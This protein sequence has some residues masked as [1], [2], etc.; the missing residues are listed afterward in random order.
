MQLVNGSTCAPV[1]GSW[2]RCV[3]KKVQ[4]LYSKIIFN[5]Y[6]CIHHR[7]HTITPRYICLHCLSLFGTESFFL[8]FKIR[9][10][11]C[12]TH[13]AM[14]AGGKKTVPPDNWALVHLLKFHTRTAL[15]KFSLISYWFWE[16]NSYTAD[17][18][19][20]RPYSSASF[21]SSPRSNPFKSRAI[22]NCTKPSD[23]PVVFAREKRWPCTLMTNSKS[24][25]SQKA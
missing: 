6:N 22:S 21:F 5:K 3:M 15:F 2:F 7:T 10:E 4:F 16:Y 11:Q 24:E 13:V 20:F 1:L 17:W 19:N 23:V 14:S 9:T 8:I 25:N 18:C 12:G